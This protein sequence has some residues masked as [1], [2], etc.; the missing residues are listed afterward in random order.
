MKFFAIS[1]GILLLP[2]PQTYASECSKTIAEEKINELCRKLSSKGP[3]IKSEWPKSLLFKNC[4]DNYIWVQ[5]TSPAIKMVMHPIKQHLNDMPIGKQLDDK[6][7]Q[8]FAEFDK[9]AKAKPS[10]AWVEYVWPKPGSDKATP[11]I[12][13]VKLCKMPSGES[14]IAGSG[15]WKDD[16]K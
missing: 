16:I 4:G 11:K 10:G 15:I 5:D 9:A 14:W 13:Y 3:D 2:A 7:F 12:S 8:L 6:K 1:L